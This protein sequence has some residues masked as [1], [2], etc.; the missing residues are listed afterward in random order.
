M[1]RCFIPRESLW[2]L[3]TTVTTA[4]QVVRLLS[5]TARPV[6]T[7]SAASAAHRAVAAPSGGRATQLVGQFELTVLVSYLRLAIQCR[8]CSAT[9]DRLGAARASTRLP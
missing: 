7:N 9:A 1:R 5:E 2:T 6:S 8:A 3:G 4:S